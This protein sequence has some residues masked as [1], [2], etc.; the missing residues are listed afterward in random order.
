MF[1]SMDYSVLSV[2]GAALMTRS[3]QAPGPLEPVVFA[4][5]E[6]AEEAYARVQHTYP[7]LRAAGE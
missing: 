2:R 1:V 4:T 3:M 6:D 5:L 7:G